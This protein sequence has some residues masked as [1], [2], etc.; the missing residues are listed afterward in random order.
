MVI[1]HIVIAGGGPTGLVSYGVLKQ[2]NQVGFW[3]RKEIKTVYTSSIGGFIG[4]LATL[5]YEWSITYDYLIERP[6][7]QA[8]APMKKDVLE[9]M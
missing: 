2:L 3:N 7:E 9:I 8:F 6:W 5:D 4:V 1:K